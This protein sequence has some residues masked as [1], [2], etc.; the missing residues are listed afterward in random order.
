MAQPQ[1]QDISAFGSLRHT[2][3]AGKVQR[4]I[5]DNITGFALGTGAMLI[6]WL[7]IPAISWNISLIGSIV[8]SLGLILIPTV[9]IWQGSKN[10]ATY[11]IEI[12]EKGFSHQAGNQSQSFRWDAVREIHCES[13]RLRIKLLDGTDL[14]VWN[15]YGTR[16]DAI[17]AHVIECMAEDLSRRKLENLP[18]NTTISCGSFRIDPAL[19][20]L[21]LPDGSTLELSKIDINVFPTSDQFILT[22]LDM[23]RFAGFST[24]EFEFKRPDLESRQTF[25]LSLVQPYPEFLGLLARMDVTINFEILRPYSALLGGD[26]KYNWSLTKGL[27]FMDFI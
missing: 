26:R 5:V 19:K 24:F 15:A 10:L 18:E 8:L 2:Y 3:R 16:F 9:I 17:I 22:P 21:E 6:C 7:V 25:S 20:T 4:F 27:D 13:G 12:F 11:R 14:S 1:S 23:S